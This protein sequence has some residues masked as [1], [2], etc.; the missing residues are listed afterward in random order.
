MVEHMSEMTAILGLAHQ[1][2]RRR[3]RRK[4]VLIDASIVAADLWCEIECTIEDRGEHGVKLKLPLS[5]ELPKHFDLVIPSEHVTI[6]GR[7]VW[8]RG[9]FMGVEFVGPPRK[10]G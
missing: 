6:P 9:P 5:V 3:G 10:A 4:S 8:R 7:N 2:D 1:P